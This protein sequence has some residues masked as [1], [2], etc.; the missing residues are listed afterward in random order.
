MY[1]AAILGVGYRT[2]EWG[3]QPRSSFAIEMRN[4]EDESLVLF[5]FPRVISRE[6][7]LAPDDDVRRMLALAERRLR[8]QH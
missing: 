7:L 4:P 8:S 2:F 1:Q 5:D 6:A 3:P